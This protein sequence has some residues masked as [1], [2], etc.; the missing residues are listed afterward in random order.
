MSRSYLTFCPLLI[1][2]TACAI[3]QGCAPL[4]LR[5]S[6]A[7]P[8]R[9]WTAGTTANPES[10]AN[11][12]TSNAA[13]VQLA[14]HVE[15]GEAA[16]QSISPLPPPALTTDIEAYQEEPGAASP[17]DLP[18]ALHLAD[19]RNPL[20]ANV[21]EQVRQAYARLERAEVLWLPSLRAGASFNRHG[22]AIQDVAGAQFPTSRGAFYSGLGAGGFG[23][24]SPLVPG[25]WANFHLADAIFQPLAAEQAAGARCGAAEATLNDTLL[26]VSLAY[27]E[28]LRAQQEVA[29]A[30]ETQRHAQTLTD[31]TR[32]Y[33]EAGQG[34]VSDAD[35]AATELALRKN[36]VVR[37]EEGVAVASARLAQLL[38]LNP[39]KQ[40]APIEPTVTPLEIV[41][42]ERPIDELLAEGWAARPELAEVRHL[43]C[44]AV[45]HWKREQLAPLIPSVI[46]GVS[47]GGM[48]AGESTEYAAGQARFDMDALAYWEL[49]N[50]GFG[51]Q[52]A[53]RETSS[54]VKQARWRQ[55]ELMDL[56]ARE[57]TEAHIQVRARRDQIAIARRGVELALQSYDA[58][59]ARIE[60]A[61]GLP[62]ETLQAL[63]ALDQSRRDYLRTVIDYNAAQFTLLRALG[64]PDEA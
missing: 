25:V 62:I 31:V 49:R 38:H 52:A 20:V 13:A 17:I 34:L 36:Q 63:Q 57:V 39:A 28:L 55:V 5:S 51:D 48:S 1:L 3:L 42:V 53:R 7:F 10:A 44:E 2:A 23:A 15:D 47:Q 61:K 58:N 21:R 27:L 6:A 14:S 9:Q 54:L 19:A 22:G 41:T 12:Q 40:F 37:A 33:A 8:S 43:V 32:A 56:V 26:R 60:E 50:F 4:P 18:T 45:A 16:D 11:R 64:W 46:L 29:I 59:V 24:G 35:R 30:E